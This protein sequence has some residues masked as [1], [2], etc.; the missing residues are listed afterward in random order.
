MVY[1][2][3]LD[4]RHRNAQPTKQTVH[5]Y[6]SFDSDNFILNRHHSVVKDW[7]RYWDF[8]TV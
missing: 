2:P 1:T 4:F 5:V 3:K 7:F 6:T 8:P